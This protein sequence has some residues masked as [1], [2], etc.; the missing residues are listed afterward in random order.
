MIAGLL[1]VGSW[2]HSDVYFTYS[3]VFKIDNGT[4]YVR[5]NFTSQDAFIAQKSIDVHAQI[6]EMGLRYPNGTIVPMP[7]PLSNNLRLG[8]Y[9]VIIVDAKKPY[10]S[11][12]DVLQNYTG[13]LIIPA[14]VTQKPTFQ[15]AGDDKVFFPLAGDYLG[16]MTIST[17]PGKVIQLGRVMEVSPPEASLQVI[18]NNIGIGLSMIVVGLTIVQIGL[19][20][21]T[22]K[23]H[24]T[25]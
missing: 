3:R 19:V 14:E 5:L 4:I 24:K 12:P 25:D 11:F 2:T 6:F 15:M 17:Y 13:A 10:E 1:Y 23:K 8:T 16:Y 21:H 7:P 20:I 18:S 9:N 22:K